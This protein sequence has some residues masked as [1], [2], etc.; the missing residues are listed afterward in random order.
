MP[1]YWS[2]KY[3][4]SWYF[5]LLESAHISFRTTCDSLIAKV[6]EQLSLGVALWC[7]FIDH[8]MRNHRRMFVVIVVV[9]IDSITD[10]YIRE[11]GKLLSKY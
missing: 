1:R 8:L 3:I 9:L 2:S 6:P 11:V 7:I 5:S 10:T 4:A